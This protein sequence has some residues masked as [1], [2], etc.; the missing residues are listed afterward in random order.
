MTLT[1]AGG[2]PIGVVEWFRLGDDA[3]VEPALER[4]ARLGITRLR[5]HLSWAD[6]HADGGAW[7]DRLFPRLAERVEVL[8]CIH[9]TPPTLA[10]TG[11]TSGPP[12]RPLDY[13]DF[14]DHV[15]DRWGQHFEWIELW[16]EPNNL[17]DWDWREDPE[18]KIFCEMIGA[19]GHWAQQR[20]WKTVLGGPCPL[21]LNWFGIMAESGVLAKIDAVGLHGFPGTWESEASSWRPW[22]G[23]LADLRS[24][25]LRFGLRPEIWLTETG[26]SSWRNDPERR[27][28]AFL[29]AV[30]AGA[31]RLYWYMLEDLDPGVPTQD[32]LRFD[33]RHYHFGLFDGGGAPSL[34]ARLLEKG[35]IGALREV[36]RLS[37]PATIGRCQPVLVAGGAGFIGC[38]LADSLAA[39]G[40]D[41]LV[42]DALSRAGA[43][44]NL[45]W[46]RRRHPRRIG[47]AIADLR[48]DIA[49]EEAVRPATAIVNLAA[50]V[51]VTTSVERP[52]EDFETNARGTLNLLEAARKR[53]E[54]PPFV[55]ASTNK[56]YGDLSDIEFSLSAGRWTPVDRTIGMR[57]IREDQPLRLCTPYGCSKGAAEQYVLDYGH[58]Y[59]MKTAVLRMSCIYGPSQFGTED[60]GWVAH[61]LIRARA[62]TPI[63][64]YGDGRQVRD[65]LH[66][67]DAVAAYRR[68]LENMQTVSGRAFN[69]G[70]G[71]RNAV[72]LL[73]VISVSERLLGRPVRTSFAATRVGD[74]AWYVSD[75][76]ALEAATGWSPNIGW[77]DGLAALSRW[78]DREARPEENSACVGTIA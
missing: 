33:V 24:L 48:D 27:I 38:N 59:G 61:F 43:E 5:T 46:L 34:T 42:L 17:N 9:F 49:V 69:V 47:A 4:M 41:V 28:N 39:D 12:R 23:Q 51:A 67:Q 64:I 37:T 68:I 63:T 45:D 3:R 70:G 16:N 75:T 66:V 11:R 73:D 7:Y 74:Q 18:W 56:V 25:L 35:G 1:S 10:V 30:D 44:E 50:Q 54:P 19:A 53:A 55:F 14:V 2:R 57:G 76:S 21:D 60:Q 32:G 40:H 20:G 71:P 78:L 26:Y 13:A 77:Q 58:T 65:I 31:D 52:L 62:G 15:L 36:R 8:P 72:S 29:D 22:P 6:F